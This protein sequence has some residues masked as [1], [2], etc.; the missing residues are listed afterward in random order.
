MIGED[1]AAEFLDGAGNAGA[2]VQ[3]VGGLADEA[4]LLISGDGTQ[5]RRSQKLGPMGSLKPLA[6][7]R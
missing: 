5:F 6:A 1:L 7:T 2:L 4:G 3:V